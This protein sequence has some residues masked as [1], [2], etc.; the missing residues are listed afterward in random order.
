[1]RFPKPDLHGLV[2]C[3]AAL[4]FLAMGARP[5]LH[6]SPDFVP[7]YTGARCLLAGCNPYE[8]PPLQEQYFQGGG[9]SAELPAWDHEPP[10]YPPS[11]LLVLSPLAVFKFPVARLVWAVLNVSLFI[12]SVVLVLSERP[13]SLRWLTTA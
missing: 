9:R 10:V 4:I 7:V 12:A 3:V 6:E 1:M 13:R 5:A 2:I 8:I 11:A